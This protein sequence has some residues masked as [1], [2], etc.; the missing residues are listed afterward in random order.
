MSQVSHQDP[1]M[2]SGTSW[3][4]QAAGHQQPQPASD[5]VLN[6]VS[7]QPTDGFD[8]HATMSASMSASAAQPQHGQRLPPPHQDQLLEPIRDGLAALQFPIDARLPS[9]SSSQSCTGPFPAT[10]VEARAD[11]PRP[12]TRALTRSREHDVAG[13]N[14]RP[15][16][17]GEAPP[18]D[19]SRRRL[20][21]SG[22]APGPDPDAASLPSALSQGLSMGCPEIPRILQQLSHPA[23]SA[24]LLLE[25][26]PGALTAAPPDWPG[27]PHTLDHPDD[28]A[29]HQ[30]PWAPDSQD[31]GV[32]SGFL[33]LLSSDQPTPRAHPP[34]DQGQPALSCEALPSCFSVPFN[35]APLPGSASPCLAH[36]QRPGLSAWHP[37]TGQAGES[38]HPSGPPLHMSEAPY[39]GYQDLPLDPSMQGT[40]GP[41]VLAHPSF[42]PWAGDL[43]EGLPLQPGLPHPELLPGP[44]IRPM[45]SAQPPSKKRQQR[46]SG[47]AVD[48]VG[49]SSLLCHLSKGAVVSSRT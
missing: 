38:G 24:E 10:Y 41:P 33:S 1:A 22:D 44:T 37:Q 16:G 28:M 26:G 14:H 2:P 31:P 9:N 30:E 21:W 47:T 32:V 4:Q 5:Q 13:S 6:V 7:A 15:P 35:F 34:V 46:D 20:Y 27:R 12:V 36:L 45:V 40:L 25:A 42:N 39:Q 49:V 17:A 19:I 43:P 11:L 48:E 29:G 23:F 8:I 3:Q 18:R